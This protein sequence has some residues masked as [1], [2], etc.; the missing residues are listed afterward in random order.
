MAQNALSM[1]K[2]GDCQLCCKLLPVRELDKPANQKCPHQKF[3]VGCTIYSNLP[4][5]CRL[6]SCQW[7]VGGEG[8]QHLPRPDRAHFVVDIMPEFITLAPHDGSPATQ[9]PVV[10]VWLDPRFPDA[11]DNDGLRRYLEKRSDQGFAALVRLNSRDG[12]VLVPPR[13][14][15]KGQWERTPLCTATAQHTPGEIAAA[16][17]KQ[18]LAITMIFKDATR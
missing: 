14:S 10:Q 16:L 9:V 6:W 3:G 13:M 8:T 2:C 5:S 12:F 4:R 18:G 7:L 17:S 15:S 1:R 11:W